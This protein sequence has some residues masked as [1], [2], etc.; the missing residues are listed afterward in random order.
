MTGFSNKF[1]S[2]SPCSGKEKVCIADGSLSNV[3]GTG[4]VKCTPTISLSYVLHVPSFPINLL[5][6]SSI[7]KALN[8]KIE[9]F[10]THCVF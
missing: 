2:Y 9:N 3:S 7:T 8:Y 10:P 1:I 6:V 4:S 5:S